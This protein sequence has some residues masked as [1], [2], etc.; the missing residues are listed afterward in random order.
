MY[1][2]VQIMRHGKG[3]HF[4]AAF[5]V[6]NSHVQSLQYT[7]SGEKLAVGFENGQVCVLVNIIF[8]IVAFLHLVVILK[9]LKTSC[10]FNHLFI[11]GGD[12]RYE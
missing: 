5:L 9:F 11:S 7:N 8:S 2:T 1:S 12:A 3:F 10:I 6:S 4:T